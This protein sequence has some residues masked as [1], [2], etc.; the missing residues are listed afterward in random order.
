MTRLEG[1]LHT[2]LVQRTT[3]EVRLTPSGM[4]LQQR[5]IAIL[6]D[7][8]EAVD[9]VASLNSGPRGLLRLTA[10]I[11][12]GV[13]VLSELLPP[14]IAQYPDVNVALDL[15]S[16]SVDLVADGVDVAIR[17]GPM[18]DSDMV[19]THLGTI[20][21]YLCAAPEYL[22]RR[23][24]PGTVEELSN[25]DIVEM[26][27]SNGLPRDWR[28]S[29]DGESSTALQIEPRISVND[30]VTI[31][32]LVM[33]GAGIGCISAYLCGADITE[34]RLVRLFPDWTLPAIGVSLVFPSNRELSP[35]VRAFV[36]YMKAVSAPGLL[37][38]QDVLE[39]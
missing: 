19:A 21:P 26:P 13:N 15:S 24:T 18:A 20:R 9:Y 22:A 11:G 5:C 28:F 33:N 31:H 17:F 29:R 16:R 1:T 36:S 37:W 23:G 34:G 14:F 25:H 12:F 4:V 2:R 30:P 32:R 39:G 3:R 38:Q 7:V 27:T 10:G 6:S 35:L 8:R